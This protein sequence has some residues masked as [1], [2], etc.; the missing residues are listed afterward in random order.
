MTESTDN[1]QQAAAGEF[2]TAASMPA[3]G[4]ASPGPA[5]LPIDDLLTRGTRSNSAVEIP[6]LLQMI[7]SGIALAIMALVVLGSFFMALGEGEFTRLD[8]FVRKARPMFAGPLEYLIQSTLLFILYSIIFAAAWQMYQR[9]NWA[10]ALVGSIL[11]VV[12]CSTCTIFTLP[13]GLW[14]IVVL[15]TKNG[16]RA[17]YS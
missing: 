8:R 1:G 16:R 17:F 9:R 5:P 4:P 10:F 14:C 7:V 12:P 6:A 2:T 11:A 13:L 15:L 3:L